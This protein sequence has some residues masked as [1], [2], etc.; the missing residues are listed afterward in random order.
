MQR[1]F[2]SL[3]SISLFL[4]SDIWG[5]EF[6]RYLIKE[7]RDSPLV[8]SFPFGIPPCLTIYVHMSSWGID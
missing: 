6:I 7:K 5:K 4:H 8:A 3:E 1:K 2:K